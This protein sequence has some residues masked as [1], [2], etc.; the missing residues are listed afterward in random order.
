MHYSGCQR[1]VPPLFFTSLPFQQFDFVRILYQE[2]RRLLY[3]EITVG[4]EFKLNLCILKYYLSNTKISMKPYRQ[5]CI[6]GIVFGLLLS[7]IWWMIVHG[8]P[9]DGSFF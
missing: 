6:I 9:G 5:G 3:D 7:G 1:V 2:G 8:Q 4:D